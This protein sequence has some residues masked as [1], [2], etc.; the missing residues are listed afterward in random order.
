[1]HSPMKVHWAHKWLTIPYAS[2]LITLHGIIPGALDCSIIEL[3]QVSAVSQS[4][5][6]STTVQ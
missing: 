3:M 4:E 5:K 6:I 2:R 1:M